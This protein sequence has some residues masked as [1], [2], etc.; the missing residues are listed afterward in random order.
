MPRPCKPRRIGELP[1][2]AVFRPGDGSPRDD[3]PIRLTL[4]EY[5]ALRLADHLN[6][7]Q[8]EAAKRMSVSRQTFGSII[9]SARSKTAGALVLG[10]AIRIDQGPSDPLL[11]HFLCSDCGTVWDAGAENEPPCGCPRCRRGRLPAKVDFLPAG[12]RR[13]RRRSGTNERKET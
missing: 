8:D 10:R 12:K 2:I 7:Y 1:R 5:E 6:L 13:C 11:C 4:D 3:D 9:A